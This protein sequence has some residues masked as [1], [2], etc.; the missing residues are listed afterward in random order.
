[1]AALGGAK[2]E[3]GGVLLE[4]AGGLALPVEPR[5]GQW[6]VNEVEKLKTYGKWS[7]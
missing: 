7:A 2:L 6:D 1:M 5:Q 3:V 4:A